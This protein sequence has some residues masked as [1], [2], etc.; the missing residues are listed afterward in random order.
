MDSTCIQGSI[1][2]LY[3]QPNERQCSNE[4]ASARR[5]PILNSKGHRVNFLAKPALRN[6][7][8]HYH[9]PICLR[10][11]GSFLRDQ[12]HCQS[13]RKPYLLDRQY[14]L[15]KDNQLNHALLFLRQTYTQHWQDNYS[16]Y[17]LHVLYNY[18][19]KLH[20]KPGFVVGSMSPPN[21]DRLCKDRYYFVH[22]ELPM[23]LSYPIYM[24]QKLEIH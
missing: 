9:A 18:A 11:F 24:E 14:L 22:A 20:Y 4:R 15:S 5:S 16:G 2:Y 10:L 13:R 7:N 8:T 12:L 1:E 6:T 23:V 19:R 3:Y 21:K 17:H